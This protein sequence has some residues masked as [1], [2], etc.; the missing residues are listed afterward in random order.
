MEH[1]A[2][3]WPTAPQFRIASPAQ[4][5]AHYIEIEP[6]DILGFAT[7]VL[8]AYLSYDFVKVHL[9]PGTKRSD[10]EPLELS[11]QQILEEFSSYMQFAW[12]K[13]ADHRGISAGRSITKAL[14]WLF[15]LG[16][17]EGRMAVKNGS[18]KNYGAPML[19]YISNRYGFPIPEEPEVLRMARGLQCCDDCDE[20][21]A[22]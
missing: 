15:I 4:I 13:A 16:D 7:E 2:Q 19:L 14:A 12:G 10:W 1:E 8:L 22:P 6:D 5:K 20:G 17:E 11:R 18:Y 21:C 9:K 3:D